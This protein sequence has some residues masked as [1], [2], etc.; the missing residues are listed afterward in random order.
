MLFACEPEGEGYDL[1]DCISILMLQSVIPN[2]IMHVSIFYFWVFY[3]NLILLETCTYNL[4]LLCFLLK[5]VVYIYIYIIN[6]FK[7]CVVVGPNFSF[8]LFAQIDFSC[9]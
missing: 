5:Y 1:Y 3:L 8:R 7:F 6:S 9:K 2:L 4:R